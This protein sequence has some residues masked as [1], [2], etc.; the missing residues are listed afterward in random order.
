LAIH[1]YTN[2]YVLLAGVHH[3]VTLSI[4]TNQ[5]VAIVKSLALKFVVH[6][7]AHVSIHVSVILPVDQAFTYCGLGVH[8]IHVGFVPSIFNVAK[9]LYPLPCHKESYA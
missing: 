5:F 1:L 8:H 2:V 4:V 6:I 9:V 7:P 3:A